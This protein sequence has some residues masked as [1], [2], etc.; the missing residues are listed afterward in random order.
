MTTRQGELYTTNKTTLT[1]DIPTD[2][3]TITITLKDPSST[4]IVDK[5]APTKDAVGQYHYD[6]TFAST[7]TP[8]NWTFQWTVDGANTD[9]VV[10]VDAKYTAIYV[11]SDR[12][13]SKLGSA[14]KDTDSDL[15]EDGLRAGDDRVNMILSKNNLDP[16]IVANSDLTNAA[17]YFASS[18]IEDS[19]Y[20]QQTNRSPS[21][22]QWEKIGNEYMESYID[23]VKEKGPASNKYQHSQTPHGHTLGQ[24]LGMDRHRRRY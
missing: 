17:I 2:P 9:E 18:D 3:T 1:N 5:A 22:V 24:V 7:A 12:V 15:I 13:L 21:A 14:I 16:P 6:Y 19:L 20:T 11:D 8:G 10:P 23:S 4:V